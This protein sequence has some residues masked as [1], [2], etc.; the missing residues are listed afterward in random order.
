[1]VLAETRASDPPVQYFLVGTPRGRLSRLEKDMLAKPWQQAREGVQVKLLAEDSE[2]Y[3]Y[4]ESVDRVS[5]ERA[6][7]KRQMKWLRKRLRELAAMEISR[8]RC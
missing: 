7:R 5:K 6:M 3:V 2:L 4:A 8:R 1:V